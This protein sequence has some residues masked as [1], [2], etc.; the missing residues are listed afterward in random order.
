MRLGD[1]CYY[2]NLEAG[3]LA[4]NGSWIGCVYILAETIRQ[5]G[6]WYGGFLF[7]YGAATVDEVVNE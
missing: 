5:L 6:A 7:D 2:V 3:M 4:L 1:I